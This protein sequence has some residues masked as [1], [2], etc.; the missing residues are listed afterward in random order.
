VEENEL[1]EGCR[2]GELR[3]FERLYETH[4]PRMKSI[5]LN[6]LSDPAEAEDAVQESFLKIY[7][8]ARAFRGA[9]TFSTW[10]Y[11]VLVNTCYDFLRRRKARP[12]AVPLDAGEPGGALPAGPDAD[13]PLRLALEKAVALL[14][15]RYRDVFL[16]FEVEGFTHA[17]IARILGIAEGT[18]KTT[19]FTAKRKLR[20]LLASAPAARMALP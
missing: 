12:A 5:A 1:F 2:S 4:A 7:R 3:A 10:T 19:L 13:H 18:S 9:A 16:L 14:K 15:P 20:R 8:G 6:L 17:E 11:R